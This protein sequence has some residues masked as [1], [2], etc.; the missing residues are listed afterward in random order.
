MEKLGL[1]LPVTEK[2]VK[3]AYFQRAREAHPDHGGAASEFM[4]V[5]RA[6]EE[7][8]EFAKRNGKR[9]P[10]IG[11]QM[12]IYVAQIEAAEIVEALG[13]IATVATLDWLEVTVGDDFAQLADR[14]QAIDL[15]GRAVTDA[16]LTRLLADPHHLPFLEEINLADTPITDA[17]AMRLMRLPKIERIDL[18]GTKVGFPLRRQLAKV[19][20]VQHVEGTSRIGEWLRGK[21]K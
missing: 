11:S 10:W 9:L 5:Q 16:D 21:G 19:P 4:E 12:P 14:L 20:G 15:S 3:Q 8:L 2:D 18:R 7:A 6:F 13:G 1:S 17:S